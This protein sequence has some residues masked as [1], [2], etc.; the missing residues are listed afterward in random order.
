MKVNGKILSPPT[1]KKKFLRKEVFTVEC[2]STLKANHKEQI[3][4]SAN[5]DKKETKSGN[6]HLDINTLW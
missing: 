5:T 1:S 3:S 4:K 2:S 6:F